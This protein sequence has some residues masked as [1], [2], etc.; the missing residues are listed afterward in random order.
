MPVGHPRKAIVVK[1]LLGAANLYELTSA[2]IPRL[3]EGEA[4]VVYRCLE[5][6]GKRHT[7]EELIVE[8]ERRHL[9]AHFK[10]LDSTTVRKSVRHHL[11]LFIKDGIVRV[12]A[13]G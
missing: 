6:Y 1:T 3:G 7:L 10:R 12:V 5:P 4:Q 2:A 9:S 13:G 8:A 11:R